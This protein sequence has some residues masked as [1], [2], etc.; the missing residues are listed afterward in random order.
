MIVP[1]STELSSSLE[2]NAETPQQPSPELTPVGV[3]DPV[4][5]KSEHNERVKDSL[6]ENLSIPG[7]KTQY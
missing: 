2:L 7:K 6:I 3:M 4:F 1:R 5:E